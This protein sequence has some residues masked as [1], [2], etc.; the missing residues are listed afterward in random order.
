MQAWYNKHELQKSFHI[1]KRLQNA[2]SALWRGL[3]PKQSARNTRRHRAGPQ[4]D[5]IEMQDIIKSQMRWPPPERNIPLWMRH[6][7]PE[8]PPILV[9]LECDD[10]I[11]CHHRVSSASNSINLGLCYISVDY[12]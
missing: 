4:T 2:F 11:P 3:Q 5:D 8:M 9:H 1:C 6:G 12:F 10:L 7:R